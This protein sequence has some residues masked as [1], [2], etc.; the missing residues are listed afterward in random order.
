M[1]ARRIALTATGVGVAAGCLG[2]WF[3]MSHGVVCI[4]V[5]TLPP[6]ALSQQVAIGS[7]VFGVAA[8]QVLSATLYSLEPGSDFSNPET[9][10]E[11]VDVSAA[12]VLAASGMVGALSSAVLAARV[13]QRHLR[14]TNGFFCVAVAIFMQWRESFAKPPRSDEEQEEP[15][16]GAVLAV[17]PPPLAMQQQVQEPGQ[18]VDP[19]STREL[20]RHMTFGFG[21]GAV[22]GFF[23]I[24]PAWMLAPLLARTAP[25]AEGLTS[26]STM[27]P[28]S[29]PGGDSSEGAGSPPPA[30]QALGPPGSSERERRT[31]CLAMVPPS[32]AAAWRHFQ[33]GHVVNA[34]G[35]ALPLATGA[36][37]GSG[38]AGWQLSDA[39]AEDEVKMILSMLLFAYGCWSVVKA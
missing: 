4:P 14:R 1:G 11:L 6:L 37:A 22:L 15:E 2:T 10:N 8:R 24:G 26:L 31:C 33:L 3:E 28:G 19:R 32:L 38:I 39:P 5:L 13:P 18:E 16:E 25:G 21:S 12:A 36:I 20:I 30:Q 35:V 7:T 23:G 17:P 34:K 9:L 27:L 29:P